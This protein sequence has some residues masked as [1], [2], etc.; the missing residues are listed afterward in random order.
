MEY[1]P[2]EEEEP[3]LGNSGSR[4]IDTLLDGQECNFAQWER[5]KEQ[6]VVSYRQSLV[7]PHCKPSSNLVWEG[8]EQRISM[9]EEG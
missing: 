6:V 8:V 9:H 7:I 1:I 3:G 4:Y 2:V 5:E